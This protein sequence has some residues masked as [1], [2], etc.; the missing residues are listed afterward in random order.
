METRSEEQRFRQWAASAVRFAH[1]RQASAAAARDGRPV[2]VSVTVEELMAK[3]RAND[4]R[5][6][7]TGLPFWQHGAGHGPTSPTIDRIIGRGHYSNRNTQVVLSCIN[8]AKGTGTTEQLCEIAR[9]LL[10]RRK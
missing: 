9:A 7:L 4:Y 10:R 3:L 8:A 6:A 1:M 5:C 2:R